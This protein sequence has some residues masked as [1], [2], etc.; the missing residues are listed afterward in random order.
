MASISDLLNWKKEVKIIRQDGTDLATVWVRIL[1][2]F[3]LQEAY[4][5]SRIASAQKR[6]ALK[7]VNSPD[8]LDEIATLEQAA[9]E[10]L[11][12]LIRTSSQN[13][14][15]NDAVAKINREDL[16]KIEEIAV[17]PDGPTLE[18]QE[19]MD[20][21]EEQTE[22][23]YQQKLQDYVDER[24]KVLDAELEGLTQDEL[25]KKATSE[26]LTIAPMSVFINELEAQ[27]IFRATFMEK[28]CKTRMYDSVEDYKREYSFIKNQLTLAYTSLELTPEQVKN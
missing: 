1:G 18:E 20:A 26:Y 2:D 21:V 8:Y 28:E 25:V 5:Q 9:P 13:T 11:K 24:T 27:K 14:F 16:P 19:K 7:D 3:D 22:K 17:E 12:T 15:L 6:Q 10:E 23:T 4:R